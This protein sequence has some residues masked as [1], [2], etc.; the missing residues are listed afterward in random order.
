MNW[1]GGLGLGSSQEVVVRP[2]IVCSR[3]VAD[4]RSKNSSEETVAMYEDDDLDQL[5]KS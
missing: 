1:V 5:L 4:C 2:K 3:L